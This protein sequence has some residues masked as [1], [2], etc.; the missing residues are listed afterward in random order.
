VV[1]GRAR[2]IFADGGTPSDGATAVVRIVRLGSA[3]V[4][5][6]RRILQTL[7]G[8]TPRP[9]A[10]RVFVDG[11]LPGESLV[12]DVELRPPGSVEQDGGGPTEL[13]LSAAI[14]VPSPPGTLV[15]ASRWDATSSG[16]PDS[17]A[18]GVLDGLR[19]LISHP[20]LAAVPVDEVRPQT[21]APTLVTTSG[22]GNG[23]GGVMALAVAALPR[24][25]VAN[26]ERAAGLAV[27]EACRQLVVGGFRPVGLAAELDGSVATSYH[28]LAT[29]QALGAM[30]KELNLPWV[31]ARTRAA[32]DVPRRSVPLA[33]L[34]VAVGE[35]DAPPRSPLPWCP[36]AGLALVLAG[37]PAVAIEASLHLD[38]SFRQCG[39]AVPPVDVAAERHL[40]R[41]LEHLQGA[42]VLRGAR[43]VG[44]G[45]LMAAL[46]TLLVAR[47]A[48]PTGEPRGPLG[49]SIETAGAGRGRRD[50]VLFGEQPGRVLLA[51]DPGDLPTVMAASEATGAP[52][53]DLGRTTADEVLI[54]RRGMNT[55]LWRI[56]ELA[57]RWRDALPLPA[58]PVRGPSLP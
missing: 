24:W 48:E 36:E 47:G 10:M 57:E 35:A 1:G 12:T 43:A 52:A 49:A 28:A 30:A 37:P 54:V 42:A 25:S 22:A 29:R 16:F 14:D 32:M 19:R 11:P 15:T 8:Q 17:P 5:E 21:S 31:G 18:A 9:A 26:P 13:S 3:D 56:A 20:S 45:G 40:W 33:P 34:V 44:E 41:F 38:L 23:E 27:L 4:R 51:V 55:V 53:L 7:A 2:V 50:A 58:P 39:G 6:G 46:V